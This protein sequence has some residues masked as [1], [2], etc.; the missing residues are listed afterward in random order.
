MCK[1]AHFSTLVKNLSYLI[2]FIL[3]TIG[4]VPPL[5]DIFRREEVNNRRGRRFH[6]FI[7]VLTGQDEAGSEEV[8][9]VMHA[10][11]TESP[12]ELLPL[13]VERQ[14]EDSVADGGS[15]IG[16]DNDR[17]GRFET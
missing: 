6:E 14:A 2:L 5:S 4:F 3:F 16:P 7:K 17:N 13:S 12:S 11:G 15:H 8:E 9:D 10:A 1:E